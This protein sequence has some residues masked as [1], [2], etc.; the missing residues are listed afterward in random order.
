MKNIINKI[1]FLLLACFISV[2]I[3]IAFSFIKNENV[4]ELKIYTAVIYS[5]IIW[6]YYL[7]SG[8][9]NEWTFTPKK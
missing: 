9:L 5:V 2:S 6:L 3:S 7:I 8:K 1:L 4:T